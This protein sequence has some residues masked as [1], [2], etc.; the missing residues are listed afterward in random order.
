MGLISW[1]AKMF[2]SINQT[3]EQNARDKIDTMLRQS[4]WA[5]QDKDKINFN[6]SPGV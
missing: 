4:G 1:I 3:P 5:V 6:A 2:N